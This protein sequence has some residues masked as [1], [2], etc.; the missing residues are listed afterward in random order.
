MGNKELDSLN[1][2]I[3]L[4]EEKIKELTEK[5]QKLESELEFYHSRKLSGRK[6]HNAK[7]Q[8]IYEDFVVK[9]E[10]GHTLIEIAKDNNLSERTI[11]RYKAYY[12][13]MKGKSGS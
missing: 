9:Y 10:N 3:R 1:E 11:Y 8:T 4:L 7:W 2:K 6:V 5:N 12:D 13:K